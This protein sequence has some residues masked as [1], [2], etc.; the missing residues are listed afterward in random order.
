MDT[1]QV[2]DSALSEGQLSMEEHRQRV[3]AATN[4]ATL[5]E[6]QS[7]V[8]DLQIHS[9]PV[10]SPK[11]KSLVGGWGIRI[12]V[13]VVM[14]LLS[15]GIGW[16]L[17]RNTASR[18]DLT[19]DPGAKPGVASPVNVSPQTAPTQAPTTA[20]PQASTQPQPPTQLL[21]LGGLSGL[22]AQIRTTFGDTMGY[23]LVVYPDHAGLTRPDSVNAHKTVAYTYGSGGWSK[24][25]GAS[26]PP[27]TTVGD[28]GKFDVQ[29]VIGALRAAPKTLHMDGG[30]PENMIIE[31]AKDGTLRV[32]LY[33]SDGHTERYLMVNADGTVRPD[34]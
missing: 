2:L 31:S 9:A 33:V 24:N 7:L 23:T 30:A 8:S 16:G 32:E 18:H 6:L 28:L 21:S 12:A 19:P 17:Y 15:I 5:G 27:D 10:Q 13:L 29:A 20:P 22:L 34:Y 25:H 3:S 14:V 11:S 4:A 26:I 1:C